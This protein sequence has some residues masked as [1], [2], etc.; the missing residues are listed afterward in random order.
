MNGRAHRYPAIA[1]DRQS[2]TP[3]S[4][5]TWRTAPSVKVLIVDDSVEIRTRLGEPLSA[6]PGVVR[7]D[8]VDSAKDARHAIHSQP[9]DVVVLDFDLPMGSGFQVLEAIRLAPA[10]VTTIVFTHDP[11]LQ[12]RRSCIQAG[13]DFF[14][15][16]S[17]EFQR[18]IDVVAGLA[19]RA[20]AAKAECGL[21]DIQDALRASEQRYDDLFE[22]A[23]GAIFTTDL[24]L[25]FTSL[26]SAAETLTGYSRDEAKGLNVAAIVA[27]ETVEVVRRKLEE[28][29]G[30][31]PASMYQTEIVTRG[32]CHV[33]IEV[34]ARLV[35]R[36]GR[37]VAAWALPATSANGNVWSR[38]FARPRRWKPSAGWPAAS[39][40]TS[41]TC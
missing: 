37:P 16:K 4:G 22:N 6:L 19:H 3:A 27:P 2:P 30:G 28:Q 34:T 12:W 39:R 35:Y 26:N 17:V 1:S 41:T 14:F 21:T 40:T 20:A 25:N 18:A 11:T 5:W 29:Q 9:P 13:A 31:R 38:D 8:A 36:E 24:D 23:P 32:G 10:P 33:P 7:V 15:D